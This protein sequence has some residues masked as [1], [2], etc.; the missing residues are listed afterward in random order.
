MTGNMYKLF[1]VEF[2]KNNAVGETRET[3]YFKESES[4]AV[5]VI[6]N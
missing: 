6:R 1:V 5:L 3:L 4:T 2:C